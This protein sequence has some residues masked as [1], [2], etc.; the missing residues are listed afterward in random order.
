MQAERIEYPVFFTYQELVYG[1][2]FVAGVTGRGRALM[3]REDD[4]AWWTLGVEPGGLADHGGT[5]DAAFA[6]FRSAF[7]EVLLDIAEECSDFDTFRSRV[8]EFVREADD[9]DGE[10]WTAA[11]KAVRAGRPCEDAHFGS[12][13]KVEYETRCT[14]EVVNLAEVPKPTPARNQVATLASAA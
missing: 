14:H 1:R 10:R 13:E 9:V 5:P 7:R 3:T 8:A 6:A 4:G 11:A 12:L 2:G